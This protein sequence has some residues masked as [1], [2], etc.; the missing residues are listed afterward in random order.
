MDKSRKR[1]SNRINA[2][3]GAREATTEANQVELSDGS[4]FLPEGGGHNALKGNVNGDEI[5]K[6]TEQ[7][8][9]GGFFKPKGLARAAEIS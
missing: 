8:E 4:L 9:S 5:R 3:T 1:R 7:Q 6:I 2:L